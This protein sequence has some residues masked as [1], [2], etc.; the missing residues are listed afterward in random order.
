M[1]QHMSIHQFK[2]EKQKQALP[3]HFPS[4]WLLG[5]VHGQEW[6]DR[7]KVKPSHWNHITAL[8]TSTF[9]LA[10]LPY[11]QR[12][13]HTPSRPPI[14]SSSES[15]YPLTAWKLPLIELKPHSES[16]SASWVVL[17]AAPAWF[18]SA[19]ASAWTASEPVASTTVFTFDSSAAA[20]SGA[21]G[22]SSAE[23]GG[24]SVAAR[25]VERQ[26]RRTRAERE[27]M[28][29]PCVGQVSVEWKSETARHW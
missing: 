7:H 18:P 29:K 20:A 15:K 6:C 8:S 27:N 17:A 26:S 5:C 21:D 16:S 19:G 25:P 28:V 9:S 24:M 14:S 13:W 11:L 22:S 23:A 10:Y 12:Y 3:T 1:N 4:E 2:N